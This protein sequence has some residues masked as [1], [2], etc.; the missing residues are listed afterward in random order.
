MKIKYLGLLFIIIFCINCKNKNNN[1]DTARQAEDE[2]I[3]ISSD[4]KKS[5]II[6]EPV[7]IEVIINEIPELTEEDEFDFNS[8]YLD[9][10]ESFRLK[11]PFFNY[12]VRQRGER[13]PE[14]MFR[15]N[16]N[17]DSVASAIEEYLIEFDIFDDSLLQNM[18]DIFFLD[19]DE[20]KYMAEIAIMGVYYNDILLGYF[21]FTFT[22]E[23]E[24]IYIA[25]HATDIS[26]HTYFNKRFQKIDD[27]MIY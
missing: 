10:E 9:V 12:R 15:L 20:D 8:Y 13:N 11:L 24:R 26:T 6:E 1:I 2:S 27:N 21:Y 19:I 25:F 3:V 17:L 18:I 22:V 23:T 7:E 4:I 5:E 16:L 14:K